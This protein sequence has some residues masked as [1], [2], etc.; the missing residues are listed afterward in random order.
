MELAEPAD[1]IIRVVVRKETYH[2]NDNHGLQVVGEGGS[3]PHHNRV[4]R[5]LVDTAFLAAF[6]A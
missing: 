3:V 2:T 6:R 1:T 5:C 4:H